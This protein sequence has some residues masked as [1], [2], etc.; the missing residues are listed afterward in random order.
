MSAVY[1]WTDVNLIGAYYRRYR[2][3]GLAGRNDI[4]SLRVIWPNHPI[5][6]KSGFVCP[7]NSLELIYVGNHSISRMPASRIT[8]WKCWNIPCWYKRSL[9]FWW[10][11]MHDVTWHTMTSKLFQIF[12]QLLLLQQHLRTVVTRSVSVDT[13]SQSCTVHDY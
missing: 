2:Q 6:V 3:C 8:L 1:L 10:G 5:E 12:F 9:L 7:C 4:S 11:N 13:C